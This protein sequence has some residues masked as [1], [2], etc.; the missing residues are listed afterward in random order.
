MTVMGTYRNGVVVPNQALDLPE[1]A[2]VRIE[3]EAAGP[4]VA[5]GSVWE[6]HALR[7][8]GLPGPDF[9]DPIAEMEA[10]LFP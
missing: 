4:I 2:T 10:P 9:E 8:G 1:G 7:L 5:P 3:A 6:R